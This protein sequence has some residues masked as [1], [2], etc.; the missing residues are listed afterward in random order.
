M[1]AESQPLLSDSPL[2]SNCFDILFRSMLTYADVCFADRLLESNWFDMLFRPML[3]YADECWT[4]SPPADK[5]ARDQLLWYAVPT[6]AD[7]CWRML[8]YAL[9]IG[10]LESNC[11]DMVFRSTTQ[12]VSS[13]QSLA[14]LTSELSPDDASSAN[15]ANPANPTNLKVL[16]P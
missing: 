5:A 8:T 14:K 16:L 15:P 3:T 12:R 6:Y 2:Q 7:V 4:L 13:S 1:T 10:P 11:F 9:Q